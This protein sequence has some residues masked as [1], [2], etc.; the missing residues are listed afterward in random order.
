VEKLTVEELRTW[1][2]AVGSSTAQKRPVA[3]K[4]QLKKPPANAED[5]RK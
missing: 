3:G 1:F 5:I 4:M 2:A